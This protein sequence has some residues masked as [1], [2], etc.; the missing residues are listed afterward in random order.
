MMPKSLRLLG[1]ARKAGRLVWGLETVESTS[2]IKLL[3]LAADAGSAVARNADRISQTRGVPLII[4][5][6]D[7]ETLGHSIGKSLCAIAALT[8]EGF[9][10]NIEI[11]FEEESPPTAGTDRN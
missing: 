6:F 3:L 9:A 7:R 2:G 5:P 1:M 10:K 11:A 8:D 4:T